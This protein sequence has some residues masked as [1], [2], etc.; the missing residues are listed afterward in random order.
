MQVRRLFGT[1]F[2]PGKPR[3]VPSV[4][5]AQVMKRGDLYLA[6][7]APRSGS[8]QQGR[9]PVIIVSH[10]AFNETADQISGRDSRTGDFRKPFQ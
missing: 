10:D 8:E 5:G 7:L 9:R 1:S 2:A 6:E 4:R 3:G